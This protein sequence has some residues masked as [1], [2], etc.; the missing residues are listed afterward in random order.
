MGYLELAK[1]W[2]HNR[3]MVIILARNRGRE[4]NV[5]KKL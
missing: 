5:S 1:K 2:R 4:L 3:R